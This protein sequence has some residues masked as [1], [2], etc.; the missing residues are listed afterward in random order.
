MLFSPP[1]PHHLL[2]HHAMWLEDVFEL[3]NNSECFCPLNSASDV[4]YILGATVRRETAKY[5]RAKSEGLLYLI[6]LNR[7]VY[8]H[9]NSYS[10][11]PIFVSEMPL[12]SGTLQLRGSFAFH[13]TPA[14]FDV[15]MELSKYVHTYIY[16]GCPR[17]NVPDFGTVFLMLKYTDITQNTCIQ[18]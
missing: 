1:P 16:T 4:I 14:L 11:R 13:I 17:R 10:H 8:F 15:C 12:P 6:L 3:S 5:E 7:A 2:E 18:S 9:E